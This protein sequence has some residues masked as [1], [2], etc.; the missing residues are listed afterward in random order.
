MDVLTPMLFEII[1]QVED[2]QEATRLG[3]APLK[4]GTNY[5]KLHSIDDRIIIWMTPF[6]IVLGK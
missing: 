4:K 2:Y 6:Y 5:L 3:A 1:E